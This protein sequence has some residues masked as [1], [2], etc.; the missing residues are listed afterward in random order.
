MSALTNRIAGTGLFALDVIVRLDGSTAKP[1]LGGSAGNVLSIL[2]ALGWTAVPIGATGDDPAARLL[3]ETFDALGADLS[4]FKRSRHRCT[5]IIYQHQL[6]A[7]ADS[8]HRFSFACPV[9]GERRRPAWDDEQWLLDEHEELPEASVFFLDRPTELGVA[10]ARHYANQG[11]LVVFEPSS[12][13]D[14]RELFQRALCAAHIVKYADERIDDLPY[15]AT[16]GPIVEIQTRGADGLRFRAPSLDGTWLTMG[17][18]A[19]PYVCDTSG[20]GDWCTA[21]FIYDLFRLGGAS[22]MTDYPTLVRALSFGQALSSLNCLTEG[23]RGLLGVWSSQKIVKSARE[24]CGR[25]VQSLMTGR[26]HPERRVDEPRL[27][28]LAGDSRLGR[29][30]DTIQDATVRCIEH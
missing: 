27:A 5:P 3:C 14:D 19:L 24:L 12:L 4:L 28:K 11:A 20:A 2:G 8:T 13:G 29:L 18:Y 26:P 25:R 23:A 15:D 7:D 16:M 1:A 6:G 9:C 22:K 21:G 10:L 30:S 17:A